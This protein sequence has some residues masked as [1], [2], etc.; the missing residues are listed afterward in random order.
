MLRMCDTAPQAFNAQQIV[1]I[2]A[3][4]RDPM[5]NAFARAGNACTHVARVRPWAGNAR[6]RARC[7]SMR[8]AWP[9][10]ARSQAA[11]LPTRAQCGRAGRRLPGNAR[12]NLRRHARVRARRRAGGMRA[13]ARGAVGQRC[14][15]LRHRAQ[16]NPRQCLKCRMACLAWTSSRT[17]KPWRTRNHSESSIRFS[18]SRSLRWWTP[19]RRRGSPTTPRTRP[20]RWR[21]SQPA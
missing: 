7:T 5:H 3:R 17:S 2:V 13:R 4:T 21:G 19:P 12:A 10:R 1:H 14:G 8:V 6:A 16:G 15:A 20:C 9:R 18:R 11:R